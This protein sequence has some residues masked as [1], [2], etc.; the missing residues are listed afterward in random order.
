VSP[1]FFTLDEANRLLPALRPLL[2]RLVAQRQELRQH[3]QLLER[4]RAR[5]SREGGV[6]PGGDLARAREA[7]GRLQASIQET[8]EQVQA[9]G[10]Q[11]KDLDVGL[12]DFPALRA[13]EPVLLCWRLGEDR[14]RFWHGLEEGF[15]GRKPMDEDPLVG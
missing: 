10:C 5:A 6:T 15:A 11:I 12:V 8:A 3:A 14:I 4:F 13:G 9:L 7:V 1:R 2:A